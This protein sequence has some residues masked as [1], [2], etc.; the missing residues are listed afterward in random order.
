MRLTKKEFFDTAVN[1]L[2][3]ERSQRDCTYRE[4]IEKAKKKYGITQEQLRQLCNGGDGYIEI[5]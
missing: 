2:F 3:E 4:A 1:I 5:D